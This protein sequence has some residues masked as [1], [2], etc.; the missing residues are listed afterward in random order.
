MN[1]ELHGSAFCADCDTDARIDRAV[2]VRI[3]NDIRNNA[4]LKVVQRERADAVLHVDVNAQRAVNRGAAAIAGAGNLSLSREAS[5][6]RAGR[7]NA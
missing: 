3:R 6:T 2:Y 4:P 1:A 7:A 5:G